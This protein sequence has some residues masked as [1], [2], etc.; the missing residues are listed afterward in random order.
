MIT[1]ISTTFTLLWG[2][3]GCPFG[4]YSLD[5]DEAF[6]ED[7]KRDTWDDF[8]EWG[9]FILGYDIYGDWSNIRNLGLD[10]SLENSNIYY[11]LLNY[12]YGP[13]DQLSVRFSAEFPSYNCFKLAPNPLMHEQL[14]SCSLETAYEFGGCDSEYTLQNHRAW[15]NDICAYYSYYDAAR[16]NDD[17]YSGVAGKTLIEELSG[18]KY[19]ASSIILVELRPGGQNAFS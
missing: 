15:F 3:L 10:G 14:F 7:I 8:D 18:K 4:F 19:L 16:F 1:F 13:L 6:D 9:M 12:K 5:D 17:D 11:G 2:P